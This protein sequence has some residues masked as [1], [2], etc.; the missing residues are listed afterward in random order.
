MARKK[1]PIGIQTFERIIKDGYAYVDKTSLVYKL[2][3]EGKAYF[4]SRPRRFGKSLLISTLE[5]Y[6]L[7]KKELFKGLA[8]DELETEWEEHP[9]F[10]I[11]FN[12]ANFDSVEV[13]TNK[14]NLFLVEW[15]CLYGQRKEEVSLSDRFAGIIKRA[16]KKT[17]KQ[18]VVLVDEYDKPLLQTIMNEKLGDQFRDILKAFYGVLK[19]S[20]E[21]LKFVLLTGVTK[22]SKISIFSDLNQLQDISMS[23][24]YDS[25][26]GITDDELKKYFQ[27]DIQLLADKENVTCA[28]MLEILRLRYDGYHFSNNLLGV[29]NPF[30]ILNVFYNL[31]LRDY[32]FQ[33]GTPTFLMELLKQ[34]HYDITDLEGVRMDANDISNYRAEVDSPIPVIYQTGYLT[35]K[36][37]NERRGNY[38]LG[39]PN[40][41]VKNGFLKF[42]APSY[43]PPITKNAFCID[44][45]MNDIEDGNVENF[46]TR[47]K[48]MIAA[49]DYTL[50]DKELKEKYFQTIFYLVFSLVGAI[51]HT[52]VHTSNGSIDAVIECDD[53]IYIFEFKLDKSVK[54]ALA[55][56]EEKNYADRY[57]TDPRQIVKIGANFNSTTHQLDEWKTIINQ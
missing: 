35:I 50:F 18:V 54:D 13:L 46:M 48:A 1:F 5:A 42:I 36:G 57:L 12:A 4:L 26:C 20:D 11:D 39:Y 28:K 7:G 40:A 25:L 27:E 53:F 2:V 49:M 43:I 23:R 8:I 32:W 37:Y 14:L 55:Q 30:S 29:Y 38:T 33:T 51:V 34:S 19:S 44:G 47:F 31:E 9:V 24:Y 17:G 41:E 16:C 15:E 3:S 22:F 21:Y 45:F 56:I 10:R 6:F 52:E